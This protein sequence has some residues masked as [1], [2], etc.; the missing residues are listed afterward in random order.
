MNE[1]KI[2]LAIEIL[3]EKIATLTKDFANNHDESLN[4]QF[5]EKIKVLNNIKDEVYLGN[6][7]YAEKVLKK[8]EE[9]KL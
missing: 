3:T 2:N 4:E 6:V 9:G 5:E 8:N 1:E 7:A